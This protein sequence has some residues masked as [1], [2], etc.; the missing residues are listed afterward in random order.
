M[1]EAFLQ[2]D[3]LQQSSGT[4]ALCYPLWVGGALL[5]NVLGKMG[6]ECVS[7]ETV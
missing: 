1:L 2:T 5:R 3:L 6:W 7:Y 4:S